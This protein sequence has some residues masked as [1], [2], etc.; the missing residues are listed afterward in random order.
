MFTLEAVQEEHARLLEGLDVRVLGD[1]SPTSMWVLQPGDML[2]LPP[3]W[4]HHGVSQDDVRVAQKI[5]TD[6]KLWG[7]EALTASRCDMRSFGTRYL[8][9]LPWHVRLALRPSAKARQGV[10]HFS[11]AREARERMRVTSPP[12]PALPARVDYYSL[13]IQPTLINLLRNGTRAL[14]MHCTLP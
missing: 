1:F 8:T 4:A 6:L 11:Q 5:V 10:H 2:Y 12:S 3:R 13:N 14:M 7:R 9:V